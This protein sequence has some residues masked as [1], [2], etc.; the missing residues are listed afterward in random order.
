VLSATSA[1]SSRSSSHTS[2]PEGKGRKALLPPG[3]KGTLEAE[4][5]GGDEGRNFI[6]LGALST[7]RQLVRRFRQPFDNDFAKRLGV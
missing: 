7:F 3:D 2:L 6:L 4:Q 1:H 5:K